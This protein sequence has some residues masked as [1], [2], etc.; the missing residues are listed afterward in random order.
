MKLGHAFNVDFA[1]RTL[2]SHGGHRSFQHELWPRYELPKSP[3][4]KIAVI[5]N[6]FDHLVSYY[7]HGPELRRDGRYCDSGWCA[8]NYTHKFQSFDAFIRAYCDPDFKWHVPLL[9]Q[10]LYS[11]LFD[12]KDNCVVDMI[13]KFESLNAAL[14]E[15]NKLGVDMH[16][17]DTKEK[18]ANTSKRRLFKTSKEYYTPE[19]RELVEKKCA[20]EL[21]VFGYDF[22][23][24]CQHARFIV[25][26]G[27]KYDVAGDRLYSV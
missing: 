6:P 7:M 22:E 23:G 13:L 8:V 24:L 15:L 25:P 2:A 1:T 17:A 3:C 12:E 26:T 9:K 19:L 4:L 5:R 18:R 20:R 14:P 27:L 21:Q 16:R 10:F 11:Q